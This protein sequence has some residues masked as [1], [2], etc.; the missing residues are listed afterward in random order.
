MAL[1]VKEEKEADT[2]PNKKKVAAL[3]PNFHPVLQVINI[4]ELAPQKPQQQL[5]F[6]VVLS[7]GNHFAQ[8]ML[9]SQ[10]T[11]L[12]SQQKLRENMII[13]VTEFMSNIVG[14]R[15]VC[16]LLQFE[17]LSQ[18][19]TRIGNPIDIAK[20]V[21]VLPDEQ[22]HAITAGGG[23]ATA[24]QPPLYNATNHA[25]ISTTTTTT[26][27]G[28]FFNN[29]TPN[30]YGR[31]SPSR[32]MTNNSTSVNHYQHHAPTAPIVTSA[33]VG[34]AITPIRNLNMYTNRWTIQARLTEKSDIRTW[35][36]AKG[37]GSLFSIDV[38]DATCD[39]RG[40]FFKE[41]VDKFYN[42][43]QVGQVYTFTGGRLKVANA[44]Y[45]TCQSGFEITFDQNSEI[46]LANDDGSIPGACYNFQK[47]AEI[48]SMPAEQHVDV[49]AVV[50]SVSQPSQFVSKTT[51]R[52]LTKSELTLVDDSGV[53]ISLTLWGQ[54]AELAARE[55]GNINN[56]NNAV[57]IAA[58]RRCKVSDYGGGKSISGCNS[59]DARIDMPAAHQ[60]AAWWRNHG[61]SASC[62]S[63]SG[64]AGGGGASG[65]AEA[66]MDRKSIAAIKEE[67]MGIQ[68]KADWLSFKGTL[69]FLKKDK[70]GGAWY[71]ACA[72]AEE[73]CKNRFKCTQTTDG[74]WYCE[75]CNNTYPNPVR[76][77]I[78]SGIVEDTTSSTWVSF[79]NEQAEMLFGGMTADE[80]FQKSYSGGTGMYDQDAYDSVF[81]KVNYTEWIFK[82]K[83]KQ[84]S[85][86]DEMRVKTSVVSLHPI[87][88]VKESQDLLAAIE[89]F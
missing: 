79:F 40:T 27:P 77:W 8:G 70:E 76:R 60:L 63:L 64:T 67:N 88:Y 29:N 37:E 32:A 45:N 73:P 17:I 26:K 68:D 65:K 3:P 52:E 23:A 41:A 13:R 34:V 30:P 21:S 18:A 20:V 78:F 24:P 44:K 87:D 74:N 61:T 50:K 69:T 55:L 6:R 84:D 2:D 38:A 80:C 16:I 35:S 10:L 86:N 31:S 9:S 49:L 36:N 46:H 75:K 4:K 28:V 7:D 1:A 5:R 19:Q 62:R 58:F 25:H 59:M 33:N 57:V 14:D 43:L 12:A 39:I 71:T 85:Y 89:K 22:P 48:E 53:E 42:L 66:L 51:G 83:V 11:H 15:M 72:N 56:N 82:C 54:K 81:A 47:I